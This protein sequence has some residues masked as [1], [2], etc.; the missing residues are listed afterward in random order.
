MQFVCPAAMLYTQLGAVCVCFKVGSPCIV[1]SSIPEPSSSCC[2]MM[3]WYWNITIPVIFSSHV[4]AG[5]TLHFPNSSIL[6]PFGDKEES[7]GPICG[8]VSSNVCGAHTPPPWN[9]QNSGKSFSTITPLL[10][11]LF[12]RPDKGFK[13]SNMGPYITHNLTF[14]W[15]GIWNNHLGWWDILLS[16]S[17]SQ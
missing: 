6:E 11:T 7:V 14:F 9:I 8:T 17:Q 4:Y 16:L 2:Q 12:L 15:R 13:A 1:A 5:Y 3:W 10:L